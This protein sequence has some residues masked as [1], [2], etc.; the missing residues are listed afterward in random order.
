VF[1]RLRLNRL[2]YLCAIVG[3]CL[4]VWLPGSETG[5]K[6]SVAPVQAPITFND[7]PST[8]PFYTEITNLGMRGIT[9]GCG[10][11]NF[12]PDG[13][14]TREQMA[15]FIIRALGVP[16][17]PTPGSQRFADV[18]LDNP[19]AGFIEEMAV[20][21]ITL[22]CGGGNY[23]PGSVVTREQM[24]AFI[25]RAIGQS[26]PPT[27]GSQRFADV[28][29]SN[30]FYSFIDQ[31]AVRGVT[32]G[33]GNG[34]YCPTGGV[35][36]AAMAAFLIR[37]FGFPDLGPPNPSAANA[38]RFLEQ[39]TWGATPALLAHVQQVGIRAYLDE[40][41]AIAS[42]GYASMP[43]EPTTIPSD[44]DANCQRDK[45]SMYPLQR[46]FFT[47]AFYADDQL[48]QRAAWSLHKII[49]VSGRDLMQP[50]WM[51]P[52]LQTL[53]RNA[54]GNYRTLLGEITLNPAMGAYLN[55]MTSTKN[56]PNENYPR[57]ILQLFSVGTEKLNIDGTVQRDGNGDPVPTY[58][59]E[60]VTGFTKIFTGWRLAAQPLPGVANYIDPM[61]LSTTNHD[62][63]SKLLL[64]GVT[65][66]ANQTGD[67]DMTA[68]LNNIFN[69]GNVGP[70]ICKQLIKQTVTSN[71]SPAYVERVA[72]VFNNN[73]SG[74]R[75]DLK[76]VWEAILLDPEAR[77]DVKAD[78]TYG[79]LREPAQLINNVLRAFGVRAASGTGNSDGYLNP[80]AVNMDQ[81]V[82]R[83][84]T[85]FSYF[86]FDYPVPNAPLVGPEFGILSASTALRRANFINT[87]VFGTIAVSG[88]AP[89]GTSL[90][91]TGLQALAGNPAQLVEE[92]N[93]RLLY[94][95]MSTEMRT[96]ITTAVN[97]VAATDTLKRA[98]TVVYLVASSS[99]YQ[100]QR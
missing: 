8:Y 87:M 72:K 76:A 5:A 42:S 28:P 20:R 14:V 37:G 33:C 7:V 51:V 58:D 47:N 49:V 79:R 66:P 78:V 64:D 59:Q 4:L 90:D 6:T 77:G 9:L 23:C 99:Q 83:P 68:A 62:T 54:F 98:R 88:N 96:S 89:S 16:T 75:G 17:P 95:R 57:E 67:Q 84:P 10:G 36:R 55:M 70:Y 74:I 15:A 2:L 12:C 31:M 85:V 86:P 3:L 30:T 43:L 26:T 18:P 63:T 56:N 80:Q 32:A 65:Q 41:F 81:D 40:Q 94:G 39:A 69:H 52:Y 11:G 22:G 44:C 73:G 61:V 50:S 48:R 25:M 29:P 97:A 45:Y 24:A 38:T 34:S 21:G 13:Y 82:L 19:F 1:N 71:P 93:Q 46:A 53:D 27:P 35:T 60:V 92:V 91:L 100:V